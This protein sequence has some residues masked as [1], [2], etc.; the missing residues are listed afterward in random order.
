MFPKPTAPHRRAAPRNPRACRI[1][2]RSALAP[3]LPGR[4]ARAIPLALGLLVAALGAAADGEG[5]KVE[6]LAKSGNSWD[7]RALP[8][9]PQGKPEISILKI[10]IPPGM[11]LPL[12]EHPVMNA[13]VLLT[14]KLKVVTEKNETLEL[15]AGDALV[16]VVDKWHYGINEGSEPAVIV[17]FYAGV[18]NSPVTVKKQ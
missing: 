6:V 1:A 2:A 12:H 18:A 13:G 16:E 11:R 9:Y 17:V 5:V 7:G 14:G 8:S 15:K 4:L 10:S 3:R